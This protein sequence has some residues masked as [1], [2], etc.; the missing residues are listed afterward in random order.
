MDALRRR[1]EQELE[2][3]PKVSGPSGGPDQIYITARLNRLLTDAEDEARTLKDE[4]VSVEH[5]LLA[6]LD[7]ERRRRPSAEG[8]RPHARAPH[9]GAAR[10]AR[11]PARH[12]ARTRRPPTR[13]WNAT[14]A[15]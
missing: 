13:R 4:Y 9:A 10:G 2:R 11:Q 5:V 1:L 14:A 6:M 8:I 12:L 7:D 15:T 3:L